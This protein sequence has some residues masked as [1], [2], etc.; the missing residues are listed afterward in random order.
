MELQAIVN[1]YAEGLAA[2][3]IDCLSPSGK[4]YLPG[5][6]MLYEDGALDEIVRYWSRVRPEHF[7]APN[8]Q[9]VRTVE[10]PGLSRTKCDHV[11]TTDG[12]DRAE[13]AIEFK[14]ISF[15]G[16]NGKR[17]DFG[18]GKVVSPF[19]KDRGVL[20]DAARLNSSPPAR[21]LAVIVFGFEYDEASVREAE[22]RHPV[23][24][25]RIREIASVLRANGGEPLSLTPL[26]E[27]AEFVLRGRRWVVGNRC[28]ARFEA[29]RHPCGGYGLVCGWEIVNPTTVQSN[30]AHPW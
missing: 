6:P 10:Y 16:D 21:R 11:L 25:M 18:T 12:G 22:Q 30:P 27:I 13:W 19:L 15:I 9:H 4:A 28:E 5:T 20:H 24:S 1:R 26:A 8:S 3:D 29:W 7:D 14:K 17:N 2:A 23:H